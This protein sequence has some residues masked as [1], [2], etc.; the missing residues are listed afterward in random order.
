MMKDDKAENILKNYTTLKTYNIKFPEVES[1]VID[2]A[3]EPKTNSP[4][5][6]KLSL[7]SER[8]SLET[9]LE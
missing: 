7:E 9:F 5:E 1:V 3:E 2:A 6:I 4:K 8:E